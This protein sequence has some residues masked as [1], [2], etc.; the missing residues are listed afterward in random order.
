MVTEYTVT[1]AAEQLGVGA[2][3]VRYQ[4]RTWGLGRVVGG[5]YLLR[6]R[7]IEFIRS[8]MG[9]CGSPGHRPDSPKY[10]KR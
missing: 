9:M 2:R 4:A 7:D 6:E 8:R 5:M 10:P 3:H 1:Q